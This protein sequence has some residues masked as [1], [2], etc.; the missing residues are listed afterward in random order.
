MNETPTEESGALTFLPLEKHQCRSHH[1]H[2]PPSANYSFD[3]YSKA[4]SLKL[5]RATRSTL[6]W[7]NCLSSRS[8]S[9]WKH[10]HRTECAGRDWRPTKNSTSPI[11]QDACICLFF[12]YKLDN[13]ED[14]DL[15]FCPLKYLHPHLG[16]IVQPQRAGPSSTF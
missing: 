11:S 6:R 3:P 4:Y 7:V 15:S 1:Y 10:P 14:L 2:K 16:K 5:Q 8:H 12:L 13:L 9:F